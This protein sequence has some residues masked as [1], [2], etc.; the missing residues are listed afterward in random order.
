MDIYSKIDE[1]LAEKQMS[2]RKMAQLLEIAPSTFQSMMMRKR[3][4]TFEN[5]VKIAEVLGVSVD[6]LYYG[7][8]VDRDYENVCDILNG[9]GLSIEES[10]LA[11]VDGYYIWHTDAE[12]PVEDRVAFEYTQL[13]DIVNRIE[14]D[15]EA[16]KRR[17]IRQRLETELFNPWAKEKPPQP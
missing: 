11:G 3:G 15:S 4:L 1:L 14:E 10:F 17:Y 16:H 13:L 2:R 8:E 7:S 12:N 5:A 6:V 9:A